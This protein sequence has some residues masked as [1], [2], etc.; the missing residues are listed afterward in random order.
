[1]DFF[2]R[3]REHLSF[4]FSKISLGNSLKMERLSE[5]MEEKSE[6]KDLLARVYKK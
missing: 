3:E 1:M 6:R 5:M 2:W 4:I